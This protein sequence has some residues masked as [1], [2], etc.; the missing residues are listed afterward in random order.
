MKISLLIFL[1]FLFIL[2]MFS[3]TTVINFRQADE[4]EKNTSYLTQSTVIVRESNRFQRNILN[5][6]SAGRGYIFTEDQTFLETYR[7]S[8]GENMAI[9]AELLPLLQDEGQRKLFV[10]IKDLFIEWE[11]DFSVLF[12]DRVG[13][14]K[15]NAD[16]KN[17]G[18]RNDM[19]IIGNENETNKSL[20]TKLRD[21]IREEYERREEQKTLLN[22]SIGFTRKISLFLTIISI[23]AGLL[24]AGLLARNLS[25]RILKMVNM[26]ENIAKGNY[27]VH[28]QDKGEDELSRLSASL[29]HMAEVLA[30][31]FSLLN[32]KNEELDQFAHIVS[33]DLKAP[34]RGI[35]NVVSWIEE[36]HASE[37][38]PKVKGYLEVIQGRLIRAENLIK[39]IL[40][41]AR[42]ETESIAD[43]EVDVHA[44]VSEIIETQIAPTALSIQVE[45]LPVIYTKKIPLLQVFSN[46]ISNAV[47]YHNKKDG[48]VKIFCKEHKEYY[49]FFV[50]DNGPGIATSHQQKIFKIFQTLQERDSF[51]STGIGLS[52]VLK[53]LDSRKEIIKVKSEIEK[54]SVFSF[55]WKKSL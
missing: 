19:Q 27:A 52:I 45:P 8:D 49:E 34:L 14:N 6:T 21:F 4:I 12:E 29:N 38:S 28:M 17:G 48:F 15:K 32:R 39:G 50:E 51:E 40:S 20:H 22:D 16:Q 42:I 33:H 35:G 5:M 41:Y 10:E 44:L 23:I 7:I 53:I 55:T 36:D 2:L 30:E 37:L 54:S 9:I 24:I 11:K 43:E 1:S 46:L 26:S 47:K 13:L 18:S 31:N 25:R 3:F